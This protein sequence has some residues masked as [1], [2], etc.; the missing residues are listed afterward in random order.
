MSSINIIFWTLPSKGSS[1]S[2]IFDSGSVF[3]IT[4][5]EVSEW[6]L[7]FEINS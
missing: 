7:S 2:F 4:K 5:S 6:Q 1:S 3:V